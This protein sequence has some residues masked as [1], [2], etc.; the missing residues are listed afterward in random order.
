MTLRPKPGDDD[1]L[2]DD[3]VDRLVVGLADLSDRGL[4]GRDEAEDL[5]DRVHRVGPDG[6]RPD[7]V[8]AIA[9]RWWTRWSCSR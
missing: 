6:C 1:M 3:Q 9:L 8:G 2:S 5:T 7:S 4:L